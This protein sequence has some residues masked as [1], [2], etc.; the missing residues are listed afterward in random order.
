METKL[1]TAV[2]IKATAQAAYDAFVD[3]DKIRRFWFTN[4]SARWES[5][6]VVALSFPEYGAG[7]FYIRIVEATAP[8]KIVFNWGDGPEETTVVITFAQVETETVVEVVE[9]G[10]NLNDPTLTE[11]LLNNKGG[12]ALALVALKAWLENGIDTLRTALYMKGDL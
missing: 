7:S 11:K 5:G 6:A 1:C 4:S 10:W 2:T 3:P 9:K 8:E 12:W